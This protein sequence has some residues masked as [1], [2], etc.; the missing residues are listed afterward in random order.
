[1]RPNTPDHLGLQVGRECT[2]LLENSEGV[3]LRRGGNGELK[4]D[5]DGSVGDWLSTEAEP[6]LLAYDDGMVQLRLNRGLLKIGGEGLE[7]AVGRDAAWFGFGERGAITLSNNAKNLTM[8]K[9]SSPEPVDVGYFGRLKYALLL[10]Q[11][12]RTTV[13]GQTRQPY[14]FATKVSLK[15]VSSLEV[16]L[17]LGRQVG[18]QGVDNSFGATVNGLIGGTSHDNSNSLAGLEMRW[19]LPSLRNIELFGE[20]SGEDSAAF[21]PTVES[22]LAGFFLPRLTDDGR[23]DLRFE[24]FQ[25]HQILYTNSTFPAGYLYEGLP[26][27]HFLGGAVQDYDLRYRHWFTARAVGSVAFAHTERGRM[28]RVAGQVIEQGN[29]W[30]GTVS[31][32]FGEYDISLRY[33]WQHVNNLLLTSGQH[34]TN[35]LAA[36]EVSYRY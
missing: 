2:P 19:R 7:L 11:F 26:M 9:L 30:R 18:G 33:G 28:G 21:W 13:S 4:F 3:C 17:N 8:L 23:N 22:Y 10:A 12:D 5:V 27:G 14:F 1:L 25:G 35:Q 15:P 20:F 34:R 36:V 32:P 29:S 16:G 31:F 6:Q 24:Y